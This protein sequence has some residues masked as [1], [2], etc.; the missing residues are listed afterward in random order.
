MPRIRTIKP[1]FWTDGDVVDM[2]PYARLLFIGSWN[3]ALC[4][5]GHVADDPRR[6]K[7]Q[8]LPGDDV[9]AVELVE[10]IIAHGRM[11]R[12]TTPDG[13]T[14]LHVK[15]FTDHQKIEKRWNPRCP[16]CDALGLNEPRSTSR[17]LSEPRASTPE[18]ADSPPTSAQEGKGKERRKTPSSADADGVFEAWWKLYPKKVGKADARKV[19]DRK[20]RKSTPDAITAGLQRWLPI[21]RDTDPQFIPYPST[22]LQRGS[23]DDELGEL[24]VD[25]I[26]GAEKFQL[27][28]TPDDLVPGSPEWQAWQREQR[29]AWVASREARARE[30][31]ARRAS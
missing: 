30:V 7:M 16:A 11:T 5:R 23:W 2:S 15:R 14:F 3:F 25:A 8:I 1:E 13:R 4:D 22:W 6:L 21:W 24:D 20:I 17:D 27:P 26:L 31:L 29:D 28:E 9:D 10:E 19:W 18:P 12:I